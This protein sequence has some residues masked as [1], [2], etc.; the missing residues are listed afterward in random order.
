MESSELE[1]VVE[2]LLPT[3][4]SGTYSRA[5]E[6]FAIDALHH[7]L[8]KLWDIVLDEQWMLAKIERHVSGRLVMRLD[9]FDFAETALGRVEALAREVRQHGLREKKAAVVMLLE[10]FEAKAAELKKYQR[11]LRTNEVDIRDMVRFFFSVWR[12]PPTQEIEDILRRV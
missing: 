1:D 10:E 6:T 12:L 11:W 5:Q 8:G 9:F 2:L 3:G 7:W 4:P